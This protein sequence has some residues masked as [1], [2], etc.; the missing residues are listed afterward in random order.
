MMN[1]ATAQNK[2]FM[3]NDTPRIPPPPSTESLASAQAQV[4]P[5]LAPQPQFLAQPVSALPPQPKGP[6]A[7]APAWHTLLIV[8]FILFSSYA[9]SI[10]LSGAKGSGGGR[11]ALY[12]GTMIQDVAL[13][14]F[15]WLGL[16]LRKTSLRELIGGRWERFEDFL[17]D[18][19]IAIGFWLA[20]LL[21]I[22][23]LQYA[24][25]IVSTNSKANVESVKQ[26]VGSLLPQNLRELLVFAALTILVGFFEEILFRGYLQKQIIAL[27]DPITGIVFSGA[28]FGLAHGY[29]GDRRMVLLAIYGMMF[30]LLAH[31]RKNL[32]PGMMAHAWQDSFS[33]IAFFILTKYKLI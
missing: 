9:A 6:Q 1:S 32:R 21:T 27:T 18:V 28:L 31:L 15:I 14:A 2:T 20:S 26:A 19:G 13:L 25:G 7:V 23:G 17:L 4:E 16:W 33:G 12:I 5:H 11:T 24:L 8:A 30:G 29:Q 22:A 10:R 3:E